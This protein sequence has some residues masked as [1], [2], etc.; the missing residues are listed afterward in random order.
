MNSKWRKGVLDHISAGFIEGRKM[1]YALQGK[2]V[3]IQYVVY[4][5]DYLCFPPPHLVVSVKCIT[6]VAIIWEL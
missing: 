6:T 5:E 2:L 1:V 3:P 4:L